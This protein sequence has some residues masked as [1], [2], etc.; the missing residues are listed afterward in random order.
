MNWLKKLRRRKAKGKRP[1]TGGARLDPHRAN[2]IGGGRSGFEKHRPKTSTGIRKSSSNKKREGFSSQDEFGMGDPVGE[3]LQDESVDIAA[4]DQ[5]SATVQRGGITDNGSVVIPSADG[6]AERASDG[7]GLNDMDTLLADLEAAEEEEERLLEEKRKKKLLRVGGI[8]DGETSS[9]PPL[10]KIE[11]EHMVE[12]PR[13]KGKK[14][15]GKKKKKKRR[16]KKR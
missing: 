4:I 3:Y 9:E 13:A 6:G 10:I 12:N 8:L 15:G 1:A 11:G 14:I 16:K 5:G 2:A 7:K